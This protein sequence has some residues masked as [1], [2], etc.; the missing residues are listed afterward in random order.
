MSAAFESRRPKRP[1]PAARAV[2]GARG[3]AAAGRAARRQDGREARARARLRADRESAP[4]G[5]PRLTAWLIRAERHHQQVH[6]EA[7]YGAEDE[8]RTAADAHREAA[9]PDVKAED[10]APHERPEAVREGG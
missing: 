5:A 4:V 9:E 3:V 6:E 2:R 10:E 8:R 1:R 7:R